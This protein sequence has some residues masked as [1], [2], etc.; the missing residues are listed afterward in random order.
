MR[1]PVI[2]GTIERRI[3]ANFRIV[4]EVMKK[5]LPS[6][7]LPEIVNG[8]AIGGVCL[9]R[10]AAI[11]PKGFPS[12][13]GIGSENAAHRIAVE[14][15]GGDRTKCGVYIPRR[16]TSSRLNSIVGGSLFPGV[17]HLASFSV[18]ESA[19]SVSVSLRSRD[20][21]TRV[22]VSG[23]VSDHFSDSSVFTSLDEASDFFKHGSF[24][25]SARRGSGR[26]DGLEL[27]CR[28]W[29]VTP[30]NVAKIV[31]SYFDD[32]RRFPKGS[33]DFD[34]ALLMRN[35]EHEWHGRESLCCDED[36][37]A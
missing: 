1:I 3:L 37:G 11:R 31:S 20:G 5:L 30:L 19:D 29:S 12:W 14:W 26:Y 27:R 36:V 10:L 22:S 6:P 34:C 24:G 18:E 35:I 8:Y 23:T 7:F 16:D 17:H 33:I 28:N 25:Y 15:S 32:E 13:F 9:I 2:E 4:P 21:E